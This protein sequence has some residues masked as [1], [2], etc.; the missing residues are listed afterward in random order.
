MAHPRYYNQTRYAGLENHMANKYANSLLQLMHYT[1]LLR[2]MALQHAASA[3][4]SAARATRS[5]TRP[6]AA[7]A[8]GLLEEETR[9]NSA[10]NLTERL[11]RFIFDRIDREYKSVAPA[12]TKLEQALFQLVSPP[13]PDELASRVLAMA[14]IENIRC[15]SCKSESTRPSQ[16]HVIDLM[17]PPRKMSQAGRTWPGGTRSARVAFAHVLKA[18]VERETTSKGW[19]SR[20]TRY[21]SLQMSKTIK[22]MPAVL[23]LNTAIRT[24]TT[25]RYGQRQ[26]GYLRRSAS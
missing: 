22:S 2:N 3:C 26:V 4:L 5:L 8:L 11:S 19:C 18:S 17:Y 21:Q 10:N 25:G 1:P 13:S 24:M 20:C 6:L 15:T 9:D 14:A 7:A 16:N 23:V 12:S